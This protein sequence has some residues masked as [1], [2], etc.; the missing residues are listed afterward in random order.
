MKRIKRAY[1]HLDYV[2]P[3]DV[4]PFVGMDMRHPDDRTPDNTPPRQISDQEFARESHDLGKL[5][6]DSP[7][8]EP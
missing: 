3:E 1:P 5:L 8:D 7:M 2:T 4:A 6:A